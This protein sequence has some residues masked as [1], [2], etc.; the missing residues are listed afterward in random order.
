MRACGDRC[1]D[2]GRLVVG[3]ASI[4]RDQFGMKR[5]EKWLVSGIVWEGWYVLLLYYEGSRVLNS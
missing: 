5:S 4:A 3:G 1:G 2:E